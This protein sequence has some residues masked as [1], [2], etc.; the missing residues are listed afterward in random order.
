MTNHKNSF[1]YRIYTCIVHTYTEVAVF[2][3]KD[4][5]KLILSKMNS[6]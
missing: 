5:N 4:V 2:S 6:I 3:A 1:L